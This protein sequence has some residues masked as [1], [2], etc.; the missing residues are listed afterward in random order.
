MER[1]KQAKFWKL[2]FKECKIFRKY[3]QVYSIPYKLSDIP[4]M[5]NFFLSH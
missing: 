4:S 3:E 1:W 2:N 5:V